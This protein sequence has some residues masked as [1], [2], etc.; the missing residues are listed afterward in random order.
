MQSLKELVDNNG[1][2]DMIMYLENAKT[3]RDGLVTEEKGAIPAFYDIYV[4]IRDQTG[5]IASVTQLL[6]N[7]EISINNIQ[8]LEI[9]QGITG[10]LRLSFSS[11][12][13]QKESK[14]VLEQHGFETLIQK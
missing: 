6:A 7:H 5:A 1:K 2:K 9:R 3:Y 14:K 12:E 11:R 4:D 10:A 8:I 13:K